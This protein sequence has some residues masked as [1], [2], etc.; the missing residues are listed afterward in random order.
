MFD[1]VPIHLLNMLVQEKVRPRLNLKL[2]RSKSGNRQRTAKVLAPLISLLHL[3][4]AV[5]SL[6]SVPD[7]V[8][9]SC[10]LHQA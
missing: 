3:Y 7:Y 1:F 2:M 4:I 5:D 9:P 8:H 6:T 10:N